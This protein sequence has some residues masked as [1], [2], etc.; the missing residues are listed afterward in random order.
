TGRLPAAVRNSAGVSVSRAHCTP[1]RVGR[2]VPT[3]P[4]LLHGQ[5]QSSCR[6]R[7]SQ[8]TP[9]GIS[10][11]GRAPRAAKL[12]RM[13]GQALGTGL[14]AIQTPRLCEA[15]RVPHF[16]AVVS[17]LAGSIFGAVLTLRDRLSFRLLFG[18]ALSRGSENSPQVG[19]RRAGASGSHTL[20]ARFPEGSW[21]SG[22]EPPNSAVEMWLRWN[23]R[24][25]RAWQRGLRTA[26]AE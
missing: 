2:T 5:T 1:R 17:A 15:A 12:G 3:S 19:S 16:G 13:A 26:R 25:V 6:A 18:R 22:H 11:S 21:Q 10:S 20:S 14:P 4:S 7:S 24:A 9:P 23:M 8:G